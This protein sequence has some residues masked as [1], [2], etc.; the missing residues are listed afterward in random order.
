[1]EDNFF[2]YLLIFLIAVL[3]FPLGVIYLILSALNWNAKKSLFLNSLF[4]CLALLASSFLVFFIYAFGYIY[5]R[6][7]DGFVFFVLFIPSL[8]IAN[9]CS[10]AAVLYSGSRQKNPTSITNYVNVE[11]Q[12][13]TMGKVWQTSAVVSVLTLLMIIGLIV[14]INDIEDKFEDKRPN[15]EGVSF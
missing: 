6:Y 2:L 4:V 10:T 8:I 14:A 11:W 13:P 5:F 7:N 9:I 1:M 3:S 12:I 15:T